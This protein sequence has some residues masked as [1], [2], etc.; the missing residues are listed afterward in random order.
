MDIHDMMWIVLAVSLAVAIILCPLC[1]DL[2][3]GVA[4]DAAVG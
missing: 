1:P 4:C 3:L 2:P